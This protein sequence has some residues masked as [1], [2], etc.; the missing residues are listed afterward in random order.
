[1]IKQLCQAQRGTGRSER[2]S[3][4]CR[5]SWAPNTRF[6]VRIFRPDQ[7][8]KHLPAQQVATESR[9]IGRKFTSRRRRMHGASSKGW[10]TTFFI[11]YI[12]LLL[13]R[14]NFFTH[15]KEKKIFVKGFRYLS[16]N[17]NRWAVLPSIL[18]SKIWCW[19]TIALHWIKQQECY[20]ALFPCFHTRDQTSWSVSS[21][22]FVRS[23][24]LTKTFPSFEVRHLRFPE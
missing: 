16:F 23:F 15:Q 13:E 17:F 9:C 4:R 7:P 20:E 3:R 8:V 5:L 1:M 11:L 24:A 19:A 18:V 21:F 22:P 2:S 14:K 12:A 6:L 10:I